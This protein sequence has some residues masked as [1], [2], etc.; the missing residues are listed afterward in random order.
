MI[1]WLNV[2]NVRS[3]EVSV[4]KLSLANNRF[5]LGAFVV[6]ILLEYI[7]LQTSFG[8]N[9]LHTTALSIT[10]W[11]IALFASL[12]I[13]LTEEIRKYFTRA[14]KLEKDLAKT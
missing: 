1:Q 8:N 14:R 12:V 4:F 5:L 9:L 2:L 3:S 11:L 6:V 7:G 13:I 10:D